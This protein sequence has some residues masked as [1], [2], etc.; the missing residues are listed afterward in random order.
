MR[1]TKTESSIDCM[2]PVLFDAGIPQYFQQKSIKQLYRY[3]L[4][5]STKTFVY[6]MI[7]LLNYTPLCKN[8]LQMTKSNARPDESAPE[9]PSFSTL[10]TPNKLITGAQPK[11]G[12]GHKM[13]TV[14]V[15][16]STLHC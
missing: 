10:R 11:A 8:M 1:E 9:E 15:V 2:I 16:F 7:D 14:S 13:Q 6:I 5:Q 12:T 4:V 3:L